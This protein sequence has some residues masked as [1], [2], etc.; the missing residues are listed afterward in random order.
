MLPTDIPSSIFL[1]GQVLFVMAAVVFAVSAIDDL[2]IDAYFYLRLT[3]RKLFIAGKYMPLSVND[4]LRPDEK[5][6]A[7]MLP[8]WQESDVIFNAV[9]N[10]VRTID[11]KNYQI[12]IGVYPNDAETGKEADRLCHAFSNVHKV[13]TDSPGPTCK[14][15]C[16][17]QIIKTIFQVEKQ[18]HIQ[19]AAV[20]MQDAEDVVH[21]WSFKLFNYLIPRFDL[22]QIPVFSL[23]RKWYEL[24]GGHYMDEFAEFHSKEILV[25]EQFAGVVPGAGVGTAYSRKAINFA[26]ASGEYFSTHSLTEDYEFS[27]RMR[28]AGLKMVFARVPLARRITGD[29][30]GVNNKKIDF[31]ATREYFPNKFWAAVR[32]KTRWTIGISFQAWKSF[33][34]KGDGKTKYL[35]W[36]DRKM[37]FFS[38]AIALGLVSIVI[39]LG[40]NLYHSISL[41]AYEFA[42]ILQENH[43][44]WSLVY[45][46]IGVMLFRIAQRHYWTHVYYGWKALPMVTIRYIW[47]GVIN[48]L[49]ISRAT[50]IFLGHLITGK[51][52]GWDKTAHDFPDEDTDIKIRQKLGDILLERGLIDQ[53]GLDSALAEHKQKKLPLGQILLLRKIIT[54]EELNDLLEIQS[55]ARSFATSP[56]PEPATRPSQQSTS[57]KAKSA[58][59]VELPTKKTI[60]ATNKPSV[61]T[62]EPVP[63]VTE[64]VRILPTAR[65]TLSTK[66]QLIARALMAKLGASESEVN[67]LF[68]EANTKGLP[69]EKFLVSEGFMSPF[70]MEFVE[71]LTRDYSKYAPSQAQ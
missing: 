19:F 41:D 34:W 3:Y 4:L 23:P 28:D 9:K 32:Q 12:F 42:P 50:K 54:E 39:F 46:N 63:T 20:I 24:T 48:Y 64:T 57:S 14:A 15:D 10:L 36:R 58:S 68:T 26:G 22:V 31:V 21:P 52:I 38:H 25:R 35:F 8:A 40:Y 17:N 29:K 16:L 6:L 56:R 59:I 47:G 5:P 66:E 30:R 11:Y 45:F 13:V 18:Q 53:K 37:I 55:G 69:L 70:V 65:K 51:T 33:G 44:F 27:F 61:A 2:L 60:R 43:P 62:D 49:A 7:L 1:A 71:S 67:L